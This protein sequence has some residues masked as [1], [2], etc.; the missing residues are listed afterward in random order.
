MNRSEAIRRLHDETFDVL[1]IGGGI[2]GAA[3]ARDAASR[4]LRT[5]LVEARDF[6]EGTSSRSS[7][8]VHGGLRYLEQFELDLVFEASRERRILLRIAPHMVR[9]LE[10]LFPLYEHGRVGRMTMTAGM[11]LYDALSLFRNIERH[12][13]LNEKEV[14]WQE[15][16]LAAEGLLGGARYFDAQVD[17]ARLVLATVVSAARQGAAVASRVEA[18][19]LLIEGGRVRGARVR[20]VSSA[21]PPPRSPAPGRSGDRGPSG[22]PDLSG[23]A[24]PS[25]D[26]GFEVSPAWDLRAQVVVNATGPWSDETAARCGASRAPL[27]RP[28]RGTHIHVR[29]ERIGHQRALIFESQQDGRVMFVL[30]WGDLTLIGT[31]DEDYDGPPEEVRPTGAD[32]R[33]LLHSANRLFPEARLTGCDVLSAWAGL[34]PLVAGEPGGEEEEVS[35]EHLILEEV[36]GFLTIAGGKLTSHRAM[37]EEVIDRAAEL[38]QAVGVEGVPES[39]TAERPL[40]GGD[41]D[42]LDELVSCVAERAAAAGIDPVASP[43]LAE[44][45]GTE[46][47][48]VL[49]LAADRPELARPLVADRPALAAQVVHAVQSEMAL[50][51]EDVVFRRTHLGLETADFGGAINR[52]AVLMRAELGWD[53]ERQA[54][55]IRRALAIRARNEL[56]R[57]ELEPAAGA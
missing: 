11:W 47:D 50:H 14:R 56:F 42:S 35:R 7:R 13:M 46:A 17:D 53:D 12:Q 15:P 18:T 24:G 20:E 36:P 38:L 41:F 34:R 21:G 6:A 27:L 8:L 33:Y 52:V 43:R 25:E 16:M 45:Y 30:P 22:R 37:A 54:A 19:G 29:R 4:G 39:R 3:A 28:T 44:A 57:A 23:A 31:T 5:A 55:E 48:E 49:A 2:T 51:V 32:V 10:F 1:V 9:P 26:A 40:P